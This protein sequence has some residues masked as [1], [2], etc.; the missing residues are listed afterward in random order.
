MNIPGF[1]TAALQDFHAKVKESLRKDDDNPS[2]D[3]IYGVR[4]YKDWR[5]WSDAIEDELK[6]RQISFDPVAW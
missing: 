2:P 3:K 6:K 4:T 5:D 1:T